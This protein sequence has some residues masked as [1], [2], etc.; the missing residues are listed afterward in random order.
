MSF[1]EIRKA[2]K[3][4]GSVEVLHEMDI[5]IEEGEFLVLVG[6]SGCGKSTLLNMIAGLE[7]FTSGEIRIK[8]KLMNGVHPS[9][10]NIAMVFQSYALY[11][12]MTVAQNIT[13][14]ME[15]HGGTKGR[16]LGSNE[17]GGG[18]VANIGASR[19]QTQP[20]VW[21]PASA[22]G[23]GPSSRARA[24]RISFRR[25]SL[26]SGRQTA[27][28]NADGNQEIASSAEHDRN[29]RDARSDRG[30]DAINEDRGH[31]SG[32]HASSSEPLGRSTTPR[33]M[34]SLPASWDRRP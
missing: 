7:D 5:D 28:R 34:F 24:G 9:K 6:P 33:R 13:F 18:D 12:N 11:P 25:A 26:Q 31:E 20:A 15:M 32:V 21:R 22:R 17:P 8:G 16:A 29:L 10:R 19:P 27:G 1:L 30:D 14:G 23:D 4:F 3:S 2:T